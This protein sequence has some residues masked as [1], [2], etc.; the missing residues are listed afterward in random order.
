MT[1]V[2]LLR[3]VSIPVEEEGKLV[4]ARH[5]LLGF[6]WVCLWLDAAVCGGCFVLKMYG[7]KLRGGAKR[8]IYQSWMMA[9]APAVSQRDVMM[10]KESFP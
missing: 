5:I 4:P 6:A 8:W 10:S 9:V 3:L 7:S 1:E 2:E